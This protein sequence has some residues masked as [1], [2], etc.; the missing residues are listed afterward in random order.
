MSVPPAAASSIAT[1]NSSHASATA[2]TTVGD[3]LLGERTSD[4]EIADLLE[5]VGARAIAEM[6]GTTLEEA[7]AGLAS[8]LSRFSFNAMRKTIATQPPTRVVGAL[9]F[10]HSTLAGATAFVSG[11]PDDARDSLQLGIALMHL[12]MPDPQGA[13][14]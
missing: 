13:G 7:T 6:F 10:A 1:P 2:W 4:H 8:L 3:V 5:A 11:L 9:R 14:T 12:S